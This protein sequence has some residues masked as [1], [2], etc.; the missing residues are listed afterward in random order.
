[1]FPP[2]FLLCRAPAIAE[3]SRCSIAERLEEQKLRRN[4]PS[5]TRTVR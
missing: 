4:D 1:M 3:L 5:Y 2:R